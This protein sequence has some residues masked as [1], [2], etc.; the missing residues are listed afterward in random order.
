[1]ARLMRRGRGS[2]RDRKSTKKNTIRPL[3]VLLASWL[4][5]ALFWSAQQGTLALII[6]ILGAATSMVY[7]LSKSAI[8]E[9]DVVVG[10]STNT[11]DPNVICPLGAHSIGNDS[12][13]ICPECKSFY[14]KSCLDSYLQRNKTDANCLRCNQVSFRTLVGLP[15]QQVQTQRVRHETYQTETARRRKDT[16]TGIRLRVSFG[17]TNIEVKAPSGMQVQYLLQAILKHLRMPNSD[18]QL[19]LARDGRILPKTRPLIDAGI[20][21][22]DQVELVLLPTSSESDHPPFGVGRLKVRILDENFEVDLECDEFATV[23]E[24]ADLTVKELGKIGQHSSVR[25]FS[26]TLEFQK[27]LRNR[28]DTLRQLKVRDGDELKLVPLSFS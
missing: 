23:G 11:Y 15:A 16:A 18:E 1:M 28:N 3:V 7:G 10:G 26:Y 4:F 8:A 12:F 13:V 5:A 22:G 2:M 27:R 24:I 14:H 25:Q 17:A 6:L 20:M 19:E 21:D 9:P